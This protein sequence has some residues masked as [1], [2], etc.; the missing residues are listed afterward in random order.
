MLSPDMP[1]PLVALLLSLSLLAGCAAPQSQ[2]PAGDHHAAVDRH[3]GLSKWLDLQQDVAEMDA[4]EI[5]TRLTRVDKSTDLDQL[6]YYGVLNQQL[7]DYGAWTVARDAFQK[8]Q[9][10]RALPKEQRQLAGIL[11]QYNQNRI[12]SYTRQRAL[13]DERAQLQLDLDRA[14][15]EK[16]QLAQKIQALTELEAAIS[17]R[18]EE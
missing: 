10:N 7:K 12:N 8:L 2:P 15:D 17:T 11:R 16:R 1:R 6:Y 4:A 18:R 14:E 9:E 5:K 3:A 13:L